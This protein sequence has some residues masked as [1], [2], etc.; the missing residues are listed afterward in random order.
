MTGES[1]VPHHS[2]A[3]EIAE[4]VSLLDLVADWRFAE[5]RLNAAKAA[6]RA[7]TVKHDDA[8]FDDARNDFD[9]LD[10][11]TCALD[12]VRLRELSRAVQGAYITLTRDL[13]AAQAQLAAQ[14]EA[15]TPSG[16][17]K[18][19]YMGEFQFEMRGVDEEGEETDIRIDTPWDTIKQI[20]AA[21]RSRAAATL[22]RDR[23]E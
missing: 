18:G 20:M 9:A 3:Q 22:A 17:T 7:G 11:Q 14:T 5:G 19:A 21:I 23:H 10:D 12:P 2:P 16:D 6:W 8:E 4:A 13:A 1:T 15:L